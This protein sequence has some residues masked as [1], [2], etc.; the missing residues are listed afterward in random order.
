[1]SSV[2]TPLP[3]MTPSITGEYITNSFCTNSTGTV[4][5]GERNEALAQF[6][7]FVSG[8]IFACAVIGN[9]IVLFGLGTRRKKLSRMNLMIAHL[10]IADPFVAFFNVSP[11]LIW[12]VTFR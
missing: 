6:E 4:P 9:S 2:N 5:S 8:L 11:Q 3:H 10:S 12:D 1:M 7:I